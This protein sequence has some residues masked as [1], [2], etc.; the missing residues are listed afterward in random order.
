[1]TMYDLIIAIVLA[2]GA[3]CSALYHIVNYPVIVFARK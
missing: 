1:M 3:D 2:V